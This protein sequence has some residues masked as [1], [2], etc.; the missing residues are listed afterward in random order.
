MWLG[1]VLELNPNHGPTHAALAE[2]YQ[3]S[4]NEDPRAII[5]ARQHAMAASESENWIVSNCWVRR[6]IDVLFR[7]S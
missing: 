5:K 2:H 6:C 3:R 7:G 1:S 4:I